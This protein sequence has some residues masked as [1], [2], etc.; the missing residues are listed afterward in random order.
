[1][2]LYRVQG[3]TDNVQ[4]HPFACAELHDRLPPGLP[5]QQNIMITIRLSTQGTS[6]LVVIE[7]SPSLLLAY[8]TIFFHMICVNV[9]LCTTFKDS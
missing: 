9:T 7:H 3:R 8:G 6:P 5:A 1:M 2:V 4:S